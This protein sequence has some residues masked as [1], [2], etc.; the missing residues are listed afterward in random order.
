MLNTHQKIK[1]FVD[2]GVDIDE[3]LCKLYISDYLPEGISIIKAGISIEDTD[4]HSDPFWTVTPKELFFDSLHNNKVIKPFQPSFFEWTEV[5]EKAI[6]EGYQILFLCMSKKFAGGYKQATISK[7]ILLKKYPGAILEIIDSKNVAAG[8]KL[9]SLKIAQDLSSMKDIDLLTYANYVRDSYIPKI[10]VFC[11]CNDGFRTYVSGRVKKAENTKESLC[12]ITTMEGNLETVYLS[13]NK[14]NILKDIL[15]EDSTKIASYELSFTADI[16]N[17]YI[18][19]ISKVVEDY[20][21]N[22]IHHKLSYASPSCTAVA[23]PYSFFL[24]V[25]YK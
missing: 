22:S 25:E 8:L 9:L 13:S 5:F 4:Y 24:G 6:Q 20:L 17:E 19:N 10:K 21:P 2:S 11:I 16:H 7:D 1:F 14:E 15:E 12:F 18:D 3:D 23:G